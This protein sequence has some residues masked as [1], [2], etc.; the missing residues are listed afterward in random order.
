MNTVENDLQKR[1]QKE[2]LKY[3]AGREIFCPSCGKVLDFRTSSI[4]TI[5]GTDGSQMVRT[6][7]TPCVVNAMPRLGEMVADDEYPVVKVEID[8]IKGTE[9]LS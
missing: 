7:C 2:L 6:Y 1:A 9:V 8:T 4:V 5:F 3:A